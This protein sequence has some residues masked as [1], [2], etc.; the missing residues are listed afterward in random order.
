MYG[1]NYFRTED[2]LVVEDYIVIDKLPPDSFPV[3]R[4]EFLRDNSSVSFEAGN[5]DIV[6]SQV[7]PTLSNLGK[8]I[9]EFFDISERRCIRIIIEN[10]E[11][12]K[13][14]GFIDNTSI[15]LDYN[16]HKPNSLWVKLTVYNAEAEWI[17][18][19]KNRS[20][21]EF[22][23]FYNSLEGQNFWLW[24]Q[25]LCQ[26]THIGFH[27][28]PD[29]SAG[30]VSK[31]SPL[32]RMFYDVGLDSI[33]ISACKGFGLLFRITTYNDTAKEDEYSTLVLNITKIELG[34][35]TVDPIEITPVLE[36]QETRQGI[37]DTYQYVGIPHVKIT[38]GDYTQGDNYQGI[39][40]AKPNS[41]SNSREYVEMRFYPLITPTSTPFAWYFLLDTGFPFGL[42]NICGKLNFYVID[43]DM[44]EKNT[45]VLRLGNTVQAIWFKNSNGAET[46]ITNLSICR[47]FVKNY[48]WTISGTNTLYVDS[49]AGDVAK[50][51]ISTQ[52][53]SYLIA[54]FEKVKNLTIKMSVPFEITSLQKA[55]MQESEYVIERITSIDSVNA[56]QKLEAFI[57]L[58]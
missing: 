10:D 30:I 41:I 1:I 26:F 49:G 13:M 23:T 22:V 37:N 54:T 3:F 34:L 58:Q 7:D 57:L 47:C 45:D 46:N 39:V 40:S 21:R 5:Y 2:S 44:V 6:F 25:D 24:M 17:N 16:Y 27:A 8:N 56:E 28:H 11:K 12:Q 4:D 43:I 52:T 9:R 18:S 53:Y 33:F 29:I 48:E 50:E 15:V 36:H 42:W 31:L 14:V 32:H 20:Y 35:D 55:I 19:L 38:P 51:F